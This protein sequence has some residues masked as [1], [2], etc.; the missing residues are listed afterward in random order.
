MTESMFQQLDQATNHMSATDLNQQLYL[1]SL[2][3]ELY[4]TYDHF[5]YAILPLYSFR[6]VLRKDFWL[7]VVKRLWPKF[8]PFALEKTD[9]HPCSF[10]DIISGDWSAAYYSH[11]WSKMVAADIFSAFQESGMNDSRALRQ[12]GER[13]RSVVLGNGG[14]CHPSETFRQFRGRDPSAYSLLSNLGLD[15]E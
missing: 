6:F 15:E 14:S 3:M 1:S 5:R 8:H 4:S 12:V 11:T 2:D 7:D 13:Y 9:S 10:T